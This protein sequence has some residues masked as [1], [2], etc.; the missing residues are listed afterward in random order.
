MLDRI[1]QY[2]NTHNLL[3]PSDNIVCGVSGGVDSMSMCN[4][5][6]DCG[7]NVSIA[8][9]NF[10]LRD[11]EANLDEDLVCE[12]AKQKEVKIHTIKFQTKQYALENNLSTQMAARDLRYNW[13]DE[14]CKEYGYTKIAIAH[15]ADDSIE[16]FF[17]NLM[18][19]TGVS[20]LSGIN[21]MNDKVVRPLLFAFRENIEQYASENGITYRTDSSNLSS[22]YL[23]NWIRLELMPKINERQSTFPNIMLSNITHITSHNSLMKQL[24]GDIAK[25]VISDNTIDL[26]EVRKYGSNS[27]EL[28]YELI[29]EWGFSAAD[30][31]AI[32][33]ST[34]SGK[35]YLS[36]SHEALLDRESLIIRKIAAEPKDCTITIYSLPIEIPN[37]I[38]IEQCSNV[39]NY[40]DAP[41]TTAYLDADK[42]KFP[43]TLRLWREGDKFA[44]LGVKGEKKVSDFL[45]DTKSSM[46]E[47]EQ[48][49]VIESDSQIV[50]LVGKRISEKFKITTTTK[51]IIKISYLCSQT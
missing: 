7:Y 43:L 38:S 19:G 30:A 26:S 50:W 45:I 8:H 5:L 12:F 17:I 51:K 34:Q 2:I 16:T 1:K 4:L 3:S 21:N 42:L 46:F 29:K 20:G 48:Q 22:H 9:C 37:I 11:S 28:L 24:V 31:A 27:C 47:K 32:L 15:N 40:K 35:V 44:P 23:R 14:L 33:K 41:N 6:I 18:R 49:M 39:C 36:H 25:R 10:S 13:F